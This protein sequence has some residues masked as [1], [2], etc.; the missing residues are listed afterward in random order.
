MLNSKTSNEGSIKKRYDELMN[1]IF[2]NIDFDS[3]GFIT[4]TKIAY[5]K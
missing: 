1:E 4:G 5:Y 3:S 2:M